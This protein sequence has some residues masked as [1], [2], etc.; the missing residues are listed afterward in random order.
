MLIA[1]EINSEYIV[2]NYSDLFPNTSFPSNGPSK[3][4]MVLNECYPVNQFKEHDAE[5]QMLVPTTP[6]LENGFVYIIKVEDK[7]S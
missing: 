4:W 5:T 1:K 3:E 7:T 2:A 6:Y